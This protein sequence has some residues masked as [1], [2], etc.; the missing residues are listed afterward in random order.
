MSRWTKGETS[1]EQKL[2]STD[3]WIARL[4]YQ[5]DNGAI[6]Y[7][8]IELYGKSQEQVEQLRNELLG[9]LQA[10]EMCGVSHG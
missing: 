5:Q 10:Q 6:W 4:H 8:K 7:N 1:I 3:V 9:F 2:K